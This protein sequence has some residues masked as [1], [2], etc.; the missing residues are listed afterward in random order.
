M[1][2]EFGRDHNLNERNGLDHGDG[3]EDLHKI[4]CIAAGP[5]FKQGK[6]LVGGQDSFDVCP[7]VAE[8]LGTKTP[9]S[10]GKSMKQL[11]A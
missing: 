1:L 10:K 2:P 9:E 11:F 6:T 4:F 7:T 5:D 3:S 8:L